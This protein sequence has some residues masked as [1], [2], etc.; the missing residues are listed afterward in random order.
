MGS[1]L[2]FMT[3]AIEKEYVVVRWTPR[4]GDGNSARNPSYSSVKLSD[5]KT[6]EL[7]HPGSKI[8]SSPQTSAECENDVRQYYKDP[9]RYM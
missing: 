6:F 5:M 4:Y 1:F 7:N 9:V 3:E 2:K 8:I